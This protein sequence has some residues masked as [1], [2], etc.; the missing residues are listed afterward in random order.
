VIY[1]VE[2]YFAKAKNLKKEIENLLDAFEIEYLKEQFTKKMAELS[3]A[4]KEKDAPAV[5]LILSECQTISEKLAKLQGL[6]RE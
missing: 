1:E 6:I 4:E 5:K 2:A 3:K